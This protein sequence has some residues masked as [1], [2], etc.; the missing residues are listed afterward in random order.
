MGTSTLY[1]YTAITSFPKKNIPI[2]IQVHF[3]D[4]SSFEQTFVSKSYWAFN[5]VLQK[6]INGGGY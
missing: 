6:L 2:T 1:E 4:F 5:T 3:N